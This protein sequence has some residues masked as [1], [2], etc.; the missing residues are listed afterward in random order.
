M[1]CG[2]SCDDGHHD[3]FFSHHPIFFVRKHSNE[4]FS[5]MSRK[6]SMSYSSI[7]TGGLAPAREGGERA[8]LQA[9]PTADVHE[10]ACVDWVEWFAAVASRDI[11]VYVGITEH[12][13][14]DEVIQ[15]RS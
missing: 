10:G 4:L 14:N 5:E 11:P 3:F 6:D 2:L 15:G 7:R 13:H 12:Q 8:R 1:L 9:R